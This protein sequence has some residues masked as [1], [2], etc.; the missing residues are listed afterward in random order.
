MLFHAAIAA[1]EAGD[2]EGAAEMWQ[3]LVQAGDPKG[4]FGLGNT[5]YDLG[6]YREAYAHLRRYTEIAPAN[7]WAWSWFGKGC[8][9]IGERDEAVSA[10]RRAIAAHEAGSADTDAP[11]LLRQLVDSDQTPD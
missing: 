1:K 4:I 5:L 7:S 9:C 3:A 10:Y 8:E 11:E 6:R 2:L